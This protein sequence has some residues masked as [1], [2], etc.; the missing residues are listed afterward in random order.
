MVLS[1]M[2]PNLK[3]IEVK[4]GIRGDNPWFLLLPPRPANARALFK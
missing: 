4:N 2:K 1:D 3:N